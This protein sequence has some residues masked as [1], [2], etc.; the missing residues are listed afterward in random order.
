VRRVFRE[1]ERIVHRDLH[2]GKVWYARAEIVVED[3]PGLLVTYWPLGAGVV[4]P[5]RPSDGAE[6]RLPVE[7]WELRPQ[8]WEG[9]YPLCHWRTDEAF[10]TWLFWGEDWVFEGW[11]INMQD[12]VSWTEQ[13]Y[14][15]TDGVIDIWVEPD[16]TWEWKDEDELDVAIANGVM[17]PKAA[18]AFRAEGLRA[19]GLMKK[20]VDPFNSVWTAWRPDPAWT[21]P[22]LPGGIG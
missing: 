11:Y 7:P 9:S 6:M 18:E 14:D 17:T 12:P 21:V 3:R 20:G 8:L 15:T 5:T 16:G 1:G 22:T 19:I 13:G 2:D 4:A 10:S